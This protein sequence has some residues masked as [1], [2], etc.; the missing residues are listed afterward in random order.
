M[1]SAHQFLLVAN[2]NAYSKDWENL[3]IIDPVFGAVI[4]L[5]LADWHV[6]AGHSLLSYECSAPLVQSQDEHRENIQSTSEDVH[7]QLTELFSPLP[8]TDF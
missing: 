2:D 8:S 7:I 3:L 5:S 1:F 6:H 4:L